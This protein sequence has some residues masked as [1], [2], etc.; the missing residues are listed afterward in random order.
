MAKPNAAAI[1]NILDT[2]IETNTVVHSDAHLM[3]KSI[4]WERLRL[5]NLI[6]IH[7]N[8]WELFHSSYVEGVWWVLKRYIRLI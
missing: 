4:Q 1:A 2:V 8:K 6:H 3:Y 7:H 5:A